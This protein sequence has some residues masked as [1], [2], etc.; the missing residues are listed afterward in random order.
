[1]PHFI[2]N[3]QQIKSQYEWTILQSHAPFGTWAWL[4]NRTLVF[5]WFQIPNYLCLII[6]IM[7]LYTSLI[8]VP[9]LFCCWL[10]AALREQNSQIVWN[11]ETKQCTIFHKNESQI[12]DLDQTCSLNVHI[13]QDPILNRRAV[14]NFLLYYQYDKQVAILRYRTE[15]DDEIAIMQKWAQ[16]LCQQS[17]IKL[18]LENHVFKD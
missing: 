6:L 1:M 2:D 15:N 8:I 4:S 16:D 12:I 14:V 17:G 11:N 5:T 7:M 10:Y 3:I 9:I 13:S 18:S